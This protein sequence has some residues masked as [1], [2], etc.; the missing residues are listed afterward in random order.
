MTTSDERRRW[1]AA[2]FEKNGSID[3]H[4]KLN[5]DRSPRVM[6]EATSKVLL[7]RVAELSGV[8]KITGPYRRQGK[9]PSYRWTVVKR[10]DVDRFIN[11]IRPLLSKQRQAEIQKVYAQSDDK[12]TPPT[13]IQPFAP[14]KPE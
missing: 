5:G 14:P 8:G 9:T 6:A 11:L 4:L 3:A 12:F 7:D 13:P 2:F 1:L 10:E